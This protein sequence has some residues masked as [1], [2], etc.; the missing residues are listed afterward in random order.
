MKSLIITLSC[1]ADETSGSFVADIFEISPKELHSMTF[2]T[3]V[4]FEEE[5]D[6]GIPGSLPIFGYFFIATC[7]CT[8]IFWT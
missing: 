8:F 4:T 2:L 6:D 3:F 7:N 5:D 1:V